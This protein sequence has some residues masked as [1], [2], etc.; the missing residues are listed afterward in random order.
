MGRLGT[1]AV[2]GAG[3]AGLSAFLELQERL[4]GEGDD[5]VLIDRR[6][7]HTFTTEIHTVAGGDEDED[8]VRVP[9]ER[10]VRRPARLHLGSVRRLELEGERPA[11][12]FDDDSLLSCDRLVLAAGYEPEY[13]HIP[14][15]REHALVLA[16]LKSALR[17]RHRLRSLA[18]SG[19]RGDGGR[20]PRVVVVGGG[21][22]GVQLVGEIAD[23]YPHLDLTL[24]EAGAQIMAGFEP[25]LAA[26]AAHSLQQRG[27]RLETGRRI[28]GARDGA[29]A[30]QGGDG[31]SFE[32]LIWTGGIRGSQLVAESG[33]ATNPK[34]QGQVDAGLRGVRASDGKTLD[35][36]FLAG[37]CSGPTD[38]ASGQAV[39]PT[40]QTAIQEGRCAG[41]NLLRAGQG[42]KP[43]AFHPHLRGMF[44]SLGHD[45]GVGVLGHTALYGMPA[46]AI[47]H[48]I[49]AHHAYD[50]G[51]LASLLGRVVHAHARAA[52]SEDQRTAT[53]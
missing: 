3:Y 44:V 14:G 2:V 27:V 7:Y 13:Y 42:Q 39:P 11:V 49:E 46:V 35:N 26:A 18:G 1:I 21:L 29:L 52:A 15:M 30:L 32:L 10:L 25:A 8:D 34:G 36:V 37:D 53:S 41:R 47:K 40:A 19:D 5:L 51:G 38:P 6:N 17:L 50:T 9:L 23:T 24:V 33:L 48:L 20:A 22:T 28:T 31:L 43:I 4:R 12:R 45:R 16:D